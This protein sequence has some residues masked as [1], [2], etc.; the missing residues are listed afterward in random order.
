LCIFWFSPSF[1]IAHPSSP[2]TYKL[3]HKVEEATMAYNAHFAL[4]EYDER[5]LGM[6][7]A[8][9]LKHGKRSSATNLKYGKRPRGG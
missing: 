4:G 2:A 3:T 1:A 8:T 5:R 7:S 6:P 9:N